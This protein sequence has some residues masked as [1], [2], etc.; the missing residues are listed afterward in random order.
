MVTARFLARADVDRLIA[1]LA[2]SGRTVI[3]PIVHDG[4][5]VYAPVTSAADLPSGWTDEQGRHVSAEPIRRFVTI[6]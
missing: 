1:V 4:A 6:P 3:G 2:E 5:V